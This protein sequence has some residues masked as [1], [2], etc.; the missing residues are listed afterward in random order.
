MKIGIIQ[1]S[2]HWQSTKNNIAKLTSM[3]DKN[4]KDEELLIFP[5]MTLTGFTMEPDKFGEEIDGEGINYFIN[6]ASK[7]KKHIFAGII[8]K[9]SGR[10]YNS[11]YH[12]NNFGIIS[13]C[14]RKIH[15]FSFAGEN[16]VYSA[17]NEPL[18]TK[19]NKTEVGLSICYDLRFPELY[20]NYGKS[21]CQIMVNIANWPVPRIEHWRALLKARAIENLS[22]M[23]GVNR[24][25]SDPHNNYNGFSSV[26]DP[27]GEELLSIPDTEGLFTVEINIEKVSQIRNSFPFL[28][29]IKLI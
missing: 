26:F 13:A 3:L 22:F 8:E 11:L 21:R 18:I 16:K 19:I 6:L 1:Y 25:G 15:P 7:S 2:P 12:F 28:E 29:D 27:A 23:I 24:V 14:Y 20:R 17:G 9:D 5:E 4:L 10:Y